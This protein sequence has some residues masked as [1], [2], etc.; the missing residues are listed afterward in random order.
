M[1]KIGIIT[2]DKV[3]NYGAELQAFALQKKLEILGFQSEIIDYT[4]YKNWRFKDTKDSTP[5][6]AMNFNQKLSYWVKYRF[7]A[8]LIDNILPLFNKSIKNRIRHFSEFHHQ[9]TKF[10][11]E[12]NSMPLLYN[13]HFDYDVYIVGSDQVWNPSSFSS[14]EPYFLTF[15]PKEAKKISYASSFGVSNIDKPLLNVFSSLLKN[16]DKISVR[17]ASGVKIVKQITGKEA[18]WVIDPTLLLTK[19]E[20][21]KY[22]KGYPNMPLKY[23]LIYQ[24][25][26]SKAIVDIALRISK[27]KK[28]PVYRICK[29]AF[30]VEKNK[31]IYNILDAG[32]SEFL[33][34]ISHAEYI[35]TDS[36]HGTAFS[37]NFKV[38]FFTIVSLKKKN[39]TRMKSL[40]EMAGLESRLFTDDITPTSIDINKKIN[41]VEVAKR[42]NK[43]KSESECY[44]LNSI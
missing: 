35:I 16:I 22:M 33:S 29:R 14:I 31:G 19:E 4:Y 9:H 28:I 34:L 41:F 8:F 10:S 43:K 1:K 25:S 39:N 36:F 6:V 21:E 17:E 44:L 18:Q 15:A 42:I 12:F 40:L 3:N 23:I 24:L 20:W 2:I 27:E 7:V 26:S 11:K 37:V 38:S 32:P 30:G 13:H 5:I